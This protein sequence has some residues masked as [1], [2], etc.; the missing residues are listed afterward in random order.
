MELV[1][2]WHEIG[3][4]KLLDIWGNEFAKFL[5][6]FMENGSIYMR[7]GYLNGMFDL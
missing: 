1:A 5:L 2:Y 3:T 4:N 7:E 6:P